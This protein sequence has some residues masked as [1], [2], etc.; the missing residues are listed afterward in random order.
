VERKALTAFLLLL[1]IWVS[2]GQMVVGDLMT[3]PSVVVASTKN[4]TMNWVTS[5]LALSSINCTGPGV[6]PFVA[7]VETEPAANHVF[8]LDANFTQEGVLACTV[9]S[10]PANGSSV[11][12][13]FNISV[14][15]EGVR[16]RLQNPNLK[17]VVYFTR[18]RGSGPYGLNVSMMLKN[19]CVG[20]GNVSVSMRPPAGIRMYAKSA[21]VY[22]LDTQNVLVDFSVP[23]STSEGN[24]SGAVT[25]S[26]AGSSI[27]G[28]V[29]LSVHWP[30]PK[31][32]VDSK[33]IGNVKSGT[34]L[35]AYVGISETLGY[36]SAEGVGCSVRFQDQTRAPQETFIGTVEPF[37]K[38]RCSIAME[39]PGTD[40]KIGDY[41]IWLKLNSTNAG[42]KTV[43]LNYTLPAPY[44]IL[45]PASLGL[46]KLTFESG[47]D[48][49]SIVLSVI[50]NGGFTPLEG[51][52]FELVEG[53][54]GWVILPDCDYVPPG[55][56]GNCTFLVSLNENAT[57]GTKEWTFNVSSKYTKP[58][59]LNATVE[60]YFIGI[61]DA[62]GELDETANFS[63]VGKFG[64]AET[65]RTNDI[66]ILNSI[67]GGEA[68]MADTAAVMSVHGGVTSLLGQSEKAYVQF[69]SGD[70]IDGGR[71]LLGAR[72][73]L[74]R[75]S[76]S[77]RSSKG[78]ETNLTKEM[79]IVY[80]ASAEFWTAFSVGMTEKLETEAAASESSNYRMAAEYYSILEQI[81]RPNSDSKAEVFKAKA[82]SMEKFYSDSVRRAGEIRRNAD[83]LLLKA[84]AGT[85]RVGGMRFILNPFSYRDSIE[86][87][88][89]AV[90][91]YEASSQLYRSAGQQ[92]ELNI[93]LSA[94]RATENEYE[95]AYRAFAMGSAAACFLIAVLIMRVIVGVQR[96]RE[97]EEDAEV[98]GVMVR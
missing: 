8:Y 66:A 62:I 41:L 50:E 93:V 91:D 59:R 42:E 95:S 54:E 17:T 28:F 22:S 15:C 52:K 40:V 7:Q 90:A 74:E 9:V 69:N 63:I 58:I 57:I 81:Y 85:F 35:T 32:A 38:A 33:S 56:T 61:D 23:D 30:G 34:N 31:L 18:P 19:D 94:L 88:K 89:L 77:Y 68:G 48:V 29:D 82:S 43:S 10:F 86:N 71:N 73:A 26:S 98:G 55:G 14:N 47:K 4:V 53:E 70:Y 60:I 24:Y 45:V 51:V 83:R 20:R 13:D 2:H 96:Y 76:S 11:T 72:M 64:Q 87:Y 37:G 49:S 97:D 12:K 39:F 5:E 6:G 27:T 46:G 92:N 84:R 44:M 67:R 16:L 1:A 79:G 80:E 36:K 21:T 25:F 3:V 65:L 75:I 78:N